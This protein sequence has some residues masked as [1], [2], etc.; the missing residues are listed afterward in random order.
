MSSFI[1]GGDAVAVFCTFEQM[2]NDVV[3]VVHMLS[4]DLIKQIQNT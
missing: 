3:N 4:S 1:Y 2:K